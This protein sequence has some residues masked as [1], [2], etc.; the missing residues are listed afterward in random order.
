MTG[1]RCQ[2]EIQVMYRLDY[3][4]RE[5]VIQTVG[6]ALPKVSRLQLVAWALEMAGWTQAEIARACGVS[7]RA[8]G[9]RLQRFYEKIGENSPGMF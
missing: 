1:S 8:I 4:D 9:R 2:G 7:Q 6:R 5:V 3:E